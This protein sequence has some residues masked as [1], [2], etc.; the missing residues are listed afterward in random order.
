[1]GM[2][3]CPDVLRELLTRITRL[4]VIFS[5]AFCLSSE[6]EPIK[7]FKDEYL[8]TPSSYAVSV[9]GTTARALNT[10]GVVPVSKIG[11]SGLQLVKPRSFLRSLDTS[12][13]REVVAYDPTQSLCPELIKT[14]QVTSC[15]PN[16]QVHASAVPN[17]PQFSNLWGM[18]S[19]GINATTAWDLGTG[20]EDVV[21]AIIDTGVDYNHPDLA[22]NIWINPRESAG[23]GSDDDNDGYIDDVYGIN[24]ITGS[25]NPF[26]DNGHGTHVAGTIGAL[27]NNGIGVAG[28]NWHVKIMPLKFLDAQGAGSLSDAIK[29]IDYMV[30]MKNRGVNIRVANNSWGGGGYSDALYQAITR[31]KDAGIIFTAAA[32]NESNDND[33]NPSYPASYDISNVVSVAAIDRNQNLASF[34]N[35]GASKV[36][37]AAPGVDIVSTF[38]G[39]RYQSLSGTSMA[40]PHVTGAL[41]LLLSHEPN[42]SYDQ[43]IARLYDSGSDV[44]SLQGVIRT[45]RKADVGRMMY[46]Q[47][48][49]LPVPTTPTT[50]AYS[51]SSIPYAPDTSADTAPVLMRADELNYLTVNLPFAFPFHGTVI[52]TVYVSPNGVV[53]TKSAPGSMDYQN[54][55]Q[56]PLNSIAALHSDLVAEQS[57]EGVRVASSSDHITIYWKARQYARKS[58]GDAEIRLTLYADGTIIDSL[59]V[60][61][62]DTQG[63]LQSQATVGL[64]GPVSSSAYTFAHNSSKVV[65]H[66]SVRFV[67]NCSGGVTPPA[68]STPQVTSVKIRGVVSGSHLTAAVSRERQIK[69]FFSGQGTGSVPLTISF[70]RMTCDISASAMLTNGSAVVRAKVPNLPDGIRKLTIGAT[71]AKDVV[72]IRALKAKSVRPRRVSSRTLDRLCTSFVQSVKQ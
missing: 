52:S 66:M 64:T 25:G 71:G 2:L 32:G 4:A 21:V 26:D 41:A 72:G 57:D 55:A 50:C 62:V 20:S 28:V 39:N 44:A 38:P 67:P 47:T 36:D 29:A 70:D 8:V 33:S 30:M 12:N 34:S 3:F 53:Y 42:L 43:A 11:S 51:L 10:L 68:D 46:G 59:G 24:A 7:V 31:A 19:S 60:T 49:P 15:S 5:F 14:G 16:F 9:A 58:S 54:S 63:A 48:N 18:S 6:A 37:I 56:A 27:G 23:N 40:T 61:D 69:V 17:D 13:G 65:D 22:Q 1:M 45:G 35:Y